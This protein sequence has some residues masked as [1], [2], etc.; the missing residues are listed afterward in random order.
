MRADVNKNAVGTERESAGGKEVRQVQQYSKYSSVISPSN[1][2]SLCRC[3]CLTRTHARTHP[4]TP[5]LCV[6][7]GASPG[8]GVKLEQ[9]GSSGSAVLA[10]LSIQRTVSDK[11]SL[12]TSATRSG[13]TT[14]TCQDTNTCE[15]RSSV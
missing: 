13:S 10:H 1:V 12:V 8:C 6:D 7:R 14:F 9:V 15:T 3:D 2:S 11:T 4:C 5:Q